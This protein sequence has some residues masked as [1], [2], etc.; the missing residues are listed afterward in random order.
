LSR[1]DEPLTA[2][3]ME[4]LRQVVQR[5]VGEPFALEPHGVE[6]VR[7]LLSDGWG[8]GRIHAGVLAD[9]AREVAR[10]L[11]EA[12]EVWRRVEQL[13]QRLGGVPA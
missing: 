3:Q 4:A 9:V 6:L 11:A 10:S 5:H 1:A 2:A 13:W 7:T 12:P 8:A